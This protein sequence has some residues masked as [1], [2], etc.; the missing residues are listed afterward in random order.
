MV[1][2]DFIYK[3]II[4]HYMKLHCIF[5]ACIGGS[6]EYPHDHE[7]ELYVERI[8][9]TMSRMAGFSI[10][11]YVVENN[12]I[13]PTLLDTIEGATI[14]YTET[15]KETWGIGK[16]EF[17]DV[18]SVCERYN[19]SEEDIVIKM[20]GRYLIE[21]PTLVEKVLYYS[22]NIDVFMKFYNFSTEKFEYY[23]CL[24]AL[25]AIRYSV[26][27]SFSVS[28]LDDIDK[29]PEVVFATYIRNTVPANRVMELRH[30]DM[31]FRGVKRLY[32]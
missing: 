4:L 19:F 18:K 22:D 21:N 2:L 29:S 5:T 7:E 30:L 27:Q 26:I 13:R 15:N 3:Y 31:Y 12:G 14:V 20:T 6:K 17:Y 16:K 24:L 23:D 9:D 10:T 8:R 25:W 32:I 28:L 1:S 11:F